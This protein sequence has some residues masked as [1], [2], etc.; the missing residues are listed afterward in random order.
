MRPWAKMI[1]TIE[2]PSGG[3]LSACQTIPSPCVKSI[4]SAPTSPR[5]KA[6]LYN[7]KIFNAT[8]L[9]VVRLLI[10]GEREE[11]H[12]AR[13]LGDTVGFW[14]ISIIAPARGD[15]GTII[16]SYGNWDLR[17]SIDNMTDKVRCL[18]TYKGNNRI[19]LSDDILYISVSGGPKGFEYRL[20][21]EAKSGM[22]LVS[23]T[24]REV[25]AI[26]F[27]GGLL[28]RLVKSRRLR[29]QVVTYLDVKEYDLDLNGIYPAYG[30]LRSCY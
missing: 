7:Y 16:Q 25:G 9:S 13:F 12:E 2:Q 23:D 21:D 8:Q 26:S 3:K 22:V 28:D 5:S 24:L 30:A 17:R 20:D 10:V 14:S 11:S 6:V 4:R 19:Q 1:L 18:A 29:V 15:L 27:E